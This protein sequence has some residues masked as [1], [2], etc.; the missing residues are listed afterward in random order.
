M[1][2]AATDVINP[3]NSIRVHEKHEISRKSRPLRRN[4]NSQEGYESIRYNISV[5]LV[6]FV[7]F[8]DN[9]FF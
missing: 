5:L 4:S 2:N 9:C 3:E 8:V 7:W 1:G 6:F